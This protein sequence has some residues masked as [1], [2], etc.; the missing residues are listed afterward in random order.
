MNTMHGILDVLQYQFHETKTI[1]Q[2]TGIKYLKNKPTNQQTLAEDHFSKLC[3]A[4]HIDQNESIFNPKN[5]TPRG[6]GCVDCHRVD[7]VQGIDVNHKN[8][9]IKIPSKNCL[10]CHNRSNRIGLS[11]FGKFESEGYGTPYKDG[12][13][14][15]RID[16]GRYYYELPADIH[17]TNAKLEC[18][19]CHTEKGVMG[20]G[21]QHSHMEDSVD[22]S[23]KDCHAPNFKQTS[24][25]GLAGMLIALNGNMPYPKQIAVT[26]KMNSPL[27]NLQRNDNNITFYR[28]LDGQA[29]DISKMSNASYH[30]SKNH[31]RLDCTACH[32]SWIPS[33]YGCHEVYFKNG[34]QYDW[35]KHKK[36]RGKWVELRSYL[37]Y[38]SPALAI[39]YNKKIM[40]TAPGCQV[41]TTIYDKNITNQG[42]HSFA[43]ASWDPHT[44]Q[45]HSRTCIDCHFNPQTLGLGAGILDIK[46]NNITFNPY[47][48]SN[49][50]GLPIKFPIDS[51]VSSNGKQFQSFSRD[52]SRGFNKKEIT[53]IVQAYKCIICHS[54]WDDKIYNDFKK[55]K[56]LFYENKTQCF[57]KID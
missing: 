48:Q 23:C 43:Y 57:K 34:K 55:S 50:S 31:Q 53:K 4:C 21:K 7:G 37:R 25:F 18:I 15:H 33:C 20:D 44:T 47:Y 2:T 17:H 52:N 49:V 36:T 54:K 30:T 12:R 14:T 56:K 8:I 19:D 6:G 29:F 22:I 10:K 45:K 11:Y 26:T 35:I 27:Y 3:A 46:D 13:L 24:N 28:K 16:K 32:S 41:I 1:K 40:P 51:L 38:E 5:Y 42:F 39:G 9:T